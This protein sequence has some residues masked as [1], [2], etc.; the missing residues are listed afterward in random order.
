VIES[1][2]QRAG[3]VTCDKATAGAVA[4]VVGQSG[5]HGGYYDPVAD[6]EPHN[7]GEKETS[8]SLP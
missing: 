2:C 6:L 3:P 5:R 8:T 4:P 1:T 7:H